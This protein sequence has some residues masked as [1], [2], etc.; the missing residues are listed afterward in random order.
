MTVA[1]DAIIYHVHI[2]TAMDG[3]ELAEAFSSRSKP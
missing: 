1:E 2:S 3:A